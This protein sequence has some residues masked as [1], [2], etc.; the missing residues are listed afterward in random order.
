MSN[1]DTDSVIPLFLDDGSRAQIAVMAEVL[2]ADF[3]WAQIVIPDLCRYS[4]YQDWLDH[5]EGFQIGLSMAGVEVSTIPVELVHFLAWCRIVPMRPSERALDQ[6]AFTLF[7]LRRPPAPVAFASVDPL[8]FQ[9]L[10]QTLEAFA[11]Y[12]DY[13]SW[14]DHR[15]SEQKRIV[16][17]GA[18]T[19]LVPINLDD[20]VVWTECL[21]ER[22]SE[23]SLDGYATL[24]LEFLAQ[25]PCD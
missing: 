6:F 3:P 17:E 18:R 21:G 15:A 8:D 4:D 13:R 1:V 2:E 20:F 24:L 14:S 9:R 19:E 23:T 7:R 25:D 22:A 10:G 12:A 5:R 11:P 16:A